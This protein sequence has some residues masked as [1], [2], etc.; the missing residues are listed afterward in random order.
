MAVRHEDFWHKLDIQQELLS[1]QEDFKEAEKKRLVEQFSNVIDITSLMDSKACR[2]LKIGLM[3]KC[4]ELNPDSKRLFAAASKEF[5]DDMLE[6]VQE[7]KAPKASK[8]LEMTPAHEKLSRKARLAEYSYLDLEKK[9]NE[10]VTKAENINSEMYGRLCEFAYDIDSWEMWKKFA[11]ILL[12]NQDDKNLRDEERVLFQCVRNSI[13]IRNN[14]IAS[15]EQGWMWEVLTMTQLEVVINK[16]LRPV[17]DLTRKILSWIKSGTQ[18]T[19]G[20]AIDAVNKS[21]WMIDNLWSKAKDSLIGIFKDWKTEIQEF[22]KEFLS[23]YEILWEP[24]NDPS[25]WFQA[26]LVQERWDDP[27]KWNKPNKEKTLLIRW[28]DEWIDIKKSDVQLWKWFLPDQLKPLIKFFEKIK[29]QF[30]NEKFNIVWH[31]LWWA[32]AQLLSAIYKKDF[33]NEVHTFNAPWIADLKKEFESK[34]EKPDQMINGKLN[35]YNTSWDYSFVYNTVNWDEIWNHWPH[36]WTTSE[37]LPWKL[38][39]MRNMRENIES[40]KKEEFEKYF[41]KF[42]IKREDKNKYRH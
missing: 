21:S 38:H 41:E 10:F 37:K 34:D 4:F 20:W 22:W 1:Q 19:I 12:W 30:P 14:I 13:D 29:S 39:F 17:W 33:I 5:T 40:M 7:R 31:S 6:I 16:K 26:V 3:N 36:L 15:S 24:V 9:W 35:D 42:S 2:D 8:T 32:L 28:T 23:K 27:K 18:K 25:T 11:L